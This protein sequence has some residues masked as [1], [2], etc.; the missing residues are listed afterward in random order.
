MTTLKEAALSYV[1]RGWAVFPLCWP[2]ELGGCGCGRGHNEKEVGKAPLTNR[3]VKDATKDEKT[4]QDWWNRWPSANIA[5]AT[6]GVSNLLVVDIDRHGDSDGDVS[7]SKLERQHGE[8]P[9]SAEVITGSGNHIYFALPSGVI[10]GN[11]AHRLGSGIDTRGDGGYVVAPPSKHRNGKYYA[12]DGAH[13]HEDIVILPDLPRWA[14]DLLRRNVSTM[15]EIANDLTLDP[16]AEVPFSK[17]EAL[18]ENNKKFKDT[19][20]KNRKDLS[21]QTNSGFEFALGNY[22]AQAG[23]SD[24]ELINLFVSFRRKWLAEPKSLNSYISTIRNIREDQA[25]ERTAEQTKQILQQ[26]LES[27]QDKPEEEARTALLESVR[28][29]LNLPIERIIRT[30]Q[31]YNDKLSGDVTYQLVFPSA[32]VNLTT[33]QILSKSSFRIKVAEGLNKQMANV[34]AKV[35][36][37]AVDNMLAAAEEE[38]LGEDITTEGQISKVVLSIIRSRGFAQDWEEAVANSDRPNAKPFIK[39][40]KHYIMAEPVRVFAEKHYGIKWT[41]RMVGLTLRKMGYER[42]HVHT[43]VNGK[44]VHARAWVIPDRLLNA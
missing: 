38:D 33:N 12:W 9:H 43:D 4:V 11:S 30:V 36:T 34:D 41:A 3:G 25:K 5:I 22:A 40:G 24:Q 8:L 13:H 1:R 7:L 18:I 20:N 21:D 42:E 10:L 26:T 27:A 19:W 2:D 23:W 32:T 28:A 6:G 44:L 31:K 29:A 35:W 14:I 15:V 39:D 37:Q 16:S 17:M